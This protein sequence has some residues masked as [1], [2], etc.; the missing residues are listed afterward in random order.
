ML[1]MYRRKI[2]WLWCLL[3]VLGFLPLSGLGM[4][5]R[6]EYTILG[7][8]NE[9]CSKFVRERQQSIGAYPDHRYIYWVTGYLTAV[10]AQT[11]NTNNIAGFTDI[12]GVMTWLET[13]CKK[14]P[15]TPF[16]EAV[17]ALVPAL[18]PERTTQA[19]E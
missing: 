14:T 9:S 2:L 10:N 6:G 16:A 5:T 7:V 12:Y 19:L 1:K 17:R 13:Y 18:Y 4:D 15:L 11:P 8:G 3:A